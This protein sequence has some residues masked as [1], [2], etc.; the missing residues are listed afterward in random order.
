[1]MRHACL[2]N[3]IEHVDGDELLLMLVSGLESVCAQVGKGLARQHF[4]DL[5]VDVIHC[6]PGAYL[7]INEPDSLDHIQK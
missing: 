3:G 1:M 2:G 7:Q 4:E 5:V 6:S